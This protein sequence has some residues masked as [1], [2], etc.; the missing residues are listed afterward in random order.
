M[1]TH[2]FYQGPK[3]LLSFL[4][5]N[6]D[7]CCRTQG[8]VLSVVRNS[9]IN[10]SFSR[11]LTALLCMWLSSGYCG[12]HQDHPSIVLSVLS[13]PILV[14]RDTS[15]SIQSSDP[16]CNAYTIPKPPSRASRSSSVCRKANPGWA[17]RCPAQGHREPRAQPA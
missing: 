9:V 17:V 15:K 6:D 11:H 5:L 16:F 12:N 10:H 2:G 8:E 14:S 3:Y 4:L 1:P 7:H 13:T